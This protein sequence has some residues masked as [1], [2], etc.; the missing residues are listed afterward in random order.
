MREKAKELQRLRMEAT[1]KGGKFSYNI[2]SSGFG[3]STGYSAPSVADV[4]NVTNDVKPY[5][6]TSTQ[7]VHLKTLSK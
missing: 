4:S 7:Y 3:S 5:N 6:Y 1:K 2:N